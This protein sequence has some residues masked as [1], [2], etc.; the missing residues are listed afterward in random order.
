MPTT[1]TQTIGY[2]AAGTTMTGGGVVTNN[3]ATHGWCFA[4]TNNGQAVAYGAT[5]VAGQT[6]MPSLQPNKTCNNTG[7]MS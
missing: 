1:G 5:S 6:V 7:L 3:D 4:A 2:I